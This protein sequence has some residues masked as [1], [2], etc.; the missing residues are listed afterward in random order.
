MPLRIETVLFIFMS[1]N[2]E[3]ILNIKCELKNINKKEK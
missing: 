2:S 1:F 3:V